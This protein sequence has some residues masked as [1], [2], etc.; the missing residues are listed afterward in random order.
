MA[1]DLKE[2]PPPRGGWKVFNS[3]VRASRAINKIMDE[4]K[5]CSRTFFQVNEDAP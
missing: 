2:K 3:E 1:L 4:L 5:S